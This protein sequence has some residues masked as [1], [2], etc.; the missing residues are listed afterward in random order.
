MP[1]HGCFDVDGSL[2]AVL[3]ATYGVGVIP[4]AIVAWML[5][6]HVRECSERRRQIYE[7]I[8]KLRV[9]FTEKYERLA[10]DVHWI[11]GRLESDG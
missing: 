11:R 4:A 10:A 6:G 1:R 3:S 9:E 7:E 8:A 2:V 5:T